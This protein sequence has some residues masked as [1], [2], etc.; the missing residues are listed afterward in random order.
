MRISEIHTFVPYEQQGYMRI[1]HFRM[2]FPKKESSDI[3][4][5]IWPTIVKPSMDICIQRSI[6]R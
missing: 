6:D 2:I 4:G 1:S 5:E 3:S